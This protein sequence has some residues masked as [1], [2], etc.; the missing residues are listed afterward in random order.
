MTKRQVDQQVFQLT[1]ELMVTWKL[2]SV[3]YLPA[4]YKY[5]PLAPCKCPS[6]N[7][8]IILQG[9]KN[10]LFKNSLFCIEVQPVND[11]VI[12][13]GGNFLQFFSI[14]KCLFFFSMLLYYKLLNI[15]PC[16]VQ[17][18]LVVYLFYI[19]SL[20]LLIPDFQFIPHPTSPQ[21]PGNQK[22]ICCICVYFCFTDVFT[23][24][25]FQI[26]CIRNVIGYLFFSS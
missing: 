8:D 26:P 20:Y 16:A 4:P 2:S 19:S 17:Q 6:S 10:F 14:L 18:D 9:R 25:M 7:S 13:S 3:H 12:V 15:V 11:V 5:Y 22:P 24:A 21:T 23:C 1:P